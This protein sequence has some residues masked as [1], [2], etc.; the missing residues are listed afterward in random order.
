[1]DII[2]LLVAV[3]L[4]LVL[5]WGIGHVPE[6]QPPQGAK[7]YPPLRWLLYVA[8]AIGAAVWLWRTYGL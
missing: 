4:F 2:K 3:L 7:P 8:L 5:A 1:M 6:P